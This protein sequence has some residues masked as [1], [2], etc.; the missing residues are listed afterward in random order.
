MVAG[1]FDARRGASLLPRPR[2]SLP[3]PTR[4]IDLHVDWLLQYAPD[5]TAFDPRVIPGS[6]P[7]PAGRRLPA[8]HPGGGHLVLPERRRVGEP[9]RPLG[10]ADRTDRPDRGRVLRPPPDRP[11]RLR[12]LGRRQGRDDLGRHRDRRV[13]RRRSG[14]PPTCPASRPSSSAASGSSSRSTPRPA[15]SAGSSAPGDDRGLLPLGREF[16]DALLAA[17]PERAAQPEGPPRPRPPQPARVRRSPRLVRGR[18]RR[19]DR[20]IPI[21]SHGTPVH[22]GFATPR[23]LPIDHL[24]RLRALG[25]FVGISV[26]PPFFAPPR[27]SRPRSGWWPRS[28]SGATRV[29]RDRHRDR[30]PGRRPD[31]AATGRRRRGGRLGPEPVRQADRQRL[32]ARQ[33]PASSWP[34]S[35]APRTCSDRAA[36]GLADLPNWQGVPGPVSADRQL[37]P[38]DGG[39]RSKVMSRI[40]IQPHLAR[41]TTLA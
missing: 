24:R 21:Y 25:G 12:P 15:P 2:D 20:L 39:V 29:R 1:I 41:G 5:S 40:E 26:S 4:L 33:R 27:R 31:L 37:R 3:M 16:L 34:G 22:D 19:V 14:R 35:P 11:R 32:A 17:V 36:T 30:L 13:R 7:A 6:R 8:D 18:P 28:R 38:S 10:R 23:A 9:P